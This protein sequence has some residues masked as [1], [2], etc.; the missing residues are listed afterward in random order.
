MPRFLNS[1]VKSTISH[2]WKYIYRGTLATFSLLIVALFLFFL[3]MIPED[4]TFHGEYTQAAEEAVRVVNKH[5]LCPSEYCKSSGVVMVSGQFRG[6][7]AQINGIRDSQALQEIASIFI[8]TFADTP[9]MRKAVIE[10]NPDKFHI[11]KTSKSSFVI[12]LKR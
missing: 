10:I 5:G 2:F 3:R 1:K 11:D 9:N 12:E 6:M 8:K 4:T 7:H